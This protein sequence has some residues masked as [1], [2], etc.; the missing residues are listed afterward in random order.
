MTVDG[1]AIEPALEQRAFAAGL[2][3][4]DELARSGIPLLPHAN[5]IDQAI[6]GLPQ[7]VK[8]DWVARGILTIDSYDDGAGMIDQYVPYWTLKSTYWWKMAFPAGKDV[9]VHHTLRAERRWHH[10]ADFSRGREA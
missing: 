8:D 5:A 1:N 4:T 3:V 2:D 10:G 6:A 7:N 9:K